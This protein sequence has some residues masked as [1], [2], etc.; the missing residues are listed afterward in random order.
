MKFHNVLDEVLS[1]QSHIMVL[2]ALQDSAQG[3]TGREIA[4]LT[5]LSHRSCLQ[6]L[7][8]LE[9][10]SIVQ[11]QRGG[12]D[13]IFRLNRKNIIVSEGILP[14]L[15]L[16][17]K[18]LD[19]LLSFIKRRLGKYAKSII[20]F[21]SVARGEETI[22]SDLDVCVIVADKPSLNRV[23]EKL[24]DL[25]PE[26]RKVFGVNLAPIFYKVTDFKKYYYG[27]KP[28]VDEITKDGILIAGLSIKK[29]LN[30]K[31]NDTEKSRSR[32]K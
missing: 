23:E 20:L 12:R 14:F 17:R 22:E 6:A 4:R 2:R 5:G 19:R 31:K 30:G 15:A 26:V 10:L 27:N 24:H 11:R 13:H 16:E 18:I 29:L 28:P 3:F 8:K 25:Q 32:K 21:G 1:A 7:S 9:D